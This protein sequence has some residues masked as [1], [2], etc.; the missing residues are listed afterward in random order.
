[1]RSISILDCTLRDGGYIN[2][3]K[4]GRSAISDIVSLLE[5]SGVETIECGFIED[6]PQDPDASVYENAEKVDSF[7]KKTGT[8]YVAMI[9]LGDIDAEKVTPRRPEGIDGIRLTF[10]KHEFEEEIRQARIL[11]SKGYDIYVQPVGTSTYTDRELLDLIER[12][13]TLHP[14]AFYI[15]DTLG[16]MYPSDVRRM[17]SIVDSNLDPETA[18]GF[19][20]HNNLQLSFSNA[21]T[22]MSVSEKRDLIIDSSVFGMG[23][24]AG[25]LTTELITQ[26]INNTYG[27]KYNIMPL[28]SVMERYLNDIYLKTPWGYSSPYYLSAVN[29]CHPNYANYLML[30]K[31]LGTE[32]ISKI[33]SLIPSESRG[34]Y[35]KKLIERLYYSFQSS[36]INDSEAISEIGK[37]LRGKRILVL[38][39]G[40]SVKTR[41]KQISEWITTN[42]AFVI[43][44][45]T[46]KKGYPADML[47]ISNALRAE[48]L[49]A[50]GL[51]NTKIIATSNFIL[52]NVSALRVDYSSLL[53][54]S[55]EPDNAGL[56]LL[57]LLAK[58][59][60]KE[61][62]LAGFDG[63]GSAA[64]D[65]VDFVSKSYMQRDAAK[66]NDRISH[67]LQHLSQS[68]SMVFVT[69]TSYVL[70]G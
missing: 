58:I 16:V 61:V 51:S 67:E 39:S 54:E 53:N 14:Y 43:H 23:R 56:M 44:V 3:W 52:K 24:G 28:L 63:F 5:E 32:S 21:Q 47:F 2:S 18:V 7:T 60:V 49:P 69:P 17:F 13:N 34:L 9:A 37:I 45:N 38:A 65:Y 50:D 55:S 26:Y 59:G 64:E 19:H 62:A 30:K 20:S 42:D 15:V 1:M 6:A 4:F 31:T 57:S 8:R 10:H 35:D 11:M 36:K 22:I 29:R 12:V 27:H 41:S 46:V 25:N 48:S 68:M 40:D 66:M 33:L 70:Q